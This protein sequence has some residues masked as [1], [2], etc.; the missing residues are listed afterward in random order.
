MRLPPLNGSMKG[1]GI[2]DLIGSMLVIII[3]A[4]VFVPVVTP[5]IVSAIAG[6]NVN[7]QF[8]A[9]NVTLTYLINLIVLISIIIG[10][11][12]RAYPEYSNMGG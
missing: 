10:I 9:V 6:Y 4:Y 5:A 1:F 2:A 11:Y 7:D 12:K 8:Y 3:Y